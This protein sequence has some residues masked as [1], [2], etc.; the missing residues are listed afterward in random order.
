MGKICDHTR[1]TSNYLPPPS[2]R[3]CMSTCWE[4]EVKGGCHFSEK[5]S[6]SLDRELEKGHSHLGTIG[7]VEQTH[8]LTFH[9]AIALAQHRAAKA[10]GFDVGGLSGP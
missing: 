7:L 9:V 5:Q 3:V 8:K 1:S 10:A 2:L 6:F 4:G